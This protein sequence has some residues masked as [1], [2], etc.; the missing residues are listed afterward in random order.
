MLINFHNRQSG[1]TKPNVG[2]PCFGVLCVRL[3]V[4]CSGVLEHEMPKVN[5]KVVHENITYYII[6]NV[7]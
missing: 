5:M 1:H 6:L 3:W 2:L 7:F 4:F